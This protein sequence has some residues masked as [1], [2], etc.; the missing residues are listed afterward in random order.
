MCLCSNG[1][2]LA[3]SFA[4]PKLNGSFLH[5]VHGSEAHEKK[6]NSTVMVGL[7][8]WNP[9]NGTNLQK[10]KN[11]RMWEEGSSRTCEIHFN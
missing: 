7:G 10:I 3:L 11:G 8:D 4:H 1:L 6:R 5:R 2:D 9:Q